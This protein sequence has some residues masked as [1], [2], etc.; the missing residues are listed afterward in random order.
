MDKKQRVYRLYKALL[1]GLK[2]FFILKHIDQTLLKK[3]IH[4][5]SLKI[6]EK[7]RVLPLKAC[8]KGAC[9]YYSFVMP[10]WIVKHYYF[11]EFMKVIVFKRLTVGFL[12]WYRNKHH[13]LRNSF[14][15]ENLMKEGVLHC[16]SFPQWVIPLCM[17]K[18]VC[19]PPWELI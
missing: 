15:H 5:P 8:M 14:K 6:E 18:H 1:I 10:F 9:S 19:L 2:Y 3:G 17:I 16:N 13:S 4:F 11:H 12:L 7:P